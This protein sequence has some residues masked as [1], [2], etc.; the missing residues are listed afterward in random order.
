MIDQLLEVLYFPEA[1]K[2]S[3]FNVTE[4]VF[5]ALFL[6]TASMIEIITLLGEEAG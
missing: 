5:N 3:N 2:F 4:F 1:V 6:L